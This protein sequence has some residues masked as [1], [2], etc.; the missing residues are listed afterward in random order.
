MVI[1][2]TDRE[3]A[4]VLAA[5]RHWQQ[6]LADNQEEGPICEHF[7]GIA[8]LTVEEIEDLYERFQGG[9]STA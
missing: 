1:C 6:D 3:R 2:L 9:T 4:T 8:P 5:L 7:D